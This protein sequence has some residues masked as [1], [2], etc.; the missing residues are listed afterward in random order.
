[1]ALLYLQFCGGL[2]VITTQFDQLQITY[3]VSFLKGA[4]Q[5]LSDSLSSSLSDW[6]GYDISHTHPAVL[7]NKQ[8]CTLCSGLGWPSLVKSWTTPVMGS[9]ENRTNICST[10]SGV[11]Y[12][13]SAW[14][15]IKFIL[16]EIEAFHGI[17]SKMHISV[18]SS[19]IHQFWVTVHAKTTMPVSVQVSI[20]IWGPLNVMTH[21]PHLLNT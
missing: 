1:M 18:G 16:R 10:L 20:S 3:H 15:G 19:I 17:H 21:F 4:V 2:L 7:W 9:F 13:V 8:L 6:R 12:A 14:E 11:V 5:E